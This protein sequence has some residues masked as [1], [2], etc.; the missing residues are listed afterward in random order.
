M[1][2][3]DK[4]LLSSKLRP[5]GGDKNKHVQRASHVTKFLARPLRGEVSRQSTLL[6]AK[7][8]APS[9]GINSACKA[10]EHSCKR[11]YVVAH[12]QVVALNPPLQEP[13]TADDGPSCPPFEPSAREP[14]SKSTSQIFL[15]TFRLPPQNVPDKLTTC[16]PIPATPGEARQPW[17]LLQCINRTNDPHR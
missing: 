13:A 17:V 2:G 12:N 15:A 14:Q 10:L 1:V 5:A 4:S 11:S 9:S 6:R 8:K 16:P 7:K 3:D